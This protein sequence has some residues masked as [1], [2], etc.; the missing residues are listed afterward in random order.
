MK[1]QEQDLDEE[2]D[3]LLALGKLIRKRH[4][5]P[6]DRSSM[7]TLARALLFIR[8]RD[9]IERRL[10]A[11]PVQLAFEEHRGTRNI[12]LK[13][14]QMGV[15]SWVAGRFFLK[16]ITARGVLTVQI[17]HTREAAEGIFRM[18]QR[19]WECLPEEFR[20]GPLRRSIANIGAMR[21]PELDSEF[22]VLSAADPNAGRGLTMQNLHCSEVARWPGNAAE[23]LAG[24]RAALSPG[25]ELILES[26]PNGAYGCFHEEWLQA[27]DPDLH[28][29]VPQASLP[30]PGFEPSQ[31]SGETIRHFFPWWLEP[32]YTAAPASDLSPEEEQLVHSRGLSLEQIGYRRDL[33]ASFRQLRSQ[34]FAEDPETCFRATGDC[35]FNIED[36]ESRLKE[37]PDP[38]ETR[39]N[40]ALLI[41][42]PPQ[43]GRTYILGVDTAGGGPE[44]DFGAIQVI[45]I[46]TGLQCAELRQRLGAFEL[47]AAAADLSGEYGD[48]LVAVERN[49]HGGTVLAYFK[50]AKPDASVYH[51][52]DQPGWL[53]TA[54]S[55]PMM[56][57]RMASLLSNSPWVFSSRRLLGECRT[58]VSLAG[59]ST[60]A[61][62]G[63]HDDC[64]MA[65]AV[66]QS[67]RAEILNGIKVT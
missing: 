12:V 6:A 56:V 8:G 22:R 58:F 21:F 57:S 34:E 32:A 33:E 51:A 20:E 39:H 13:A 23:T 15:T 1:K 27:I 49:N 52:A 19:F 43:S 26:T 16:T 2:I 36:I 62:N 14:R 45:E 53:T 64:F 3:S 55:K 48:A 66:A 11:N 65:M 9:G 46:Q 35:C 38:I 28:A 18:V 41:W 44:G 4:K 67:V 37:V 10:K 30:R 47:A 17:A 61:A 29:R 59:G 54:A 5:E 42:L 63:A 24:L 50:I 40:G 31:R 60:G 7:V 25:G